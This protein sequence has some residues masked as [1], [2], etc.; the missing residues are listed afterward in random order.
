MS[1]TE[2]GNNN[3]ELEGQDFNAAYESSVDKSAEPIKFHSAK[4]INIVGISNLSKSK[5]FDPDQLNKS[6]LT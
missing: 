4:K 2:Q 6:V 3:K 1:V 5:H